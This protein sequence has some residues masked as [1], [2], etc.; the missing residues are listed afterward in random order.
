MRDKRSI[1]RTLILLELI[2][3]R[4]K[5][6]EISANIDITMQG[7]SEYIRAMEK[8]GLIKDGELTLKGW[9]FLDRALSE[10]GDFVY[11]A[12]NIINKVSTTEAI[13][14]EKINAGE[15]VG[16]FME[17]GY[18]HAYRKKSSSTGTAV[19]SAK[20][21]EAV[22][23]KNLRGILEVQYGKI[24]VYSLPPAENGEVDPERIDGAL[25]NHK[26]WKIGVA[27]V[28]AYLAVKDHASIDFEFS[29]VNAAIDAHYR[30]IST[31][32]FSSHEIVP[33]ILDTLNRKGVKY[34]LKSLE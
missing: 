10:L 23:V 28:V 15:E 9:E 31:V 14:G 25:K 27:G 12:Q 4:R 7:V 32:I 3:G 6:R 1:T 11:S 29:A 8:E 22:C 13:A 5:L 26:N 17:K 30:G 2:Q 34:Q 24:T 20:P 18:L 21:G 19:N 16:L 33:S